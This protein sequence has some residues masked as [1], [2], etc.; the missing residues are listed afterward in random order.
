VVRLTNDQARGLAAS[1]LVLK[2][3]LIDGEWNLRDINHQLARD[4]N[5]GRL[6]GAVYQA[7]INREQSAI[8]EVSLNHVID[9]LIEQLKAQVKA[10]AEILDAVV[11]AI[12][13]PYAG[14][15]LAGGTLSALQRSIL[16]PDDYSELRRKLAELHCSNCT[17][18]FAENGEM[19]TVTSGDRVT[20]L[21][22]SCAVPPRMA[23]N[24]GN[25]ESSVPVPQKLRESIGNGIHCGCTEEKPAVKVKFKQEKFRPIRLDDFNLNA[26]LPRDH[27]VFVGGE[28]EQMLEPMEDE[29]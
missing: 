20:L 21:C 27:M 11:S 9:F 18:P 29:G 5:S 19:A 22:S 28:M 2:S 23:C 10:P 1:L 4:V 14:N 24:K 15:I 26:A 16:K 25:C 8:P 12:S 7:L 13:S 17:K 3:R 6:D